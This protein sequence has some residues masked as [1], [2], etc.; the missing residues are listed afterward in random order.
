MV[1]FHPIGIIITLLF[2]G[3]WGFIIYAVFALL[4][5]AKAT[6][7]ALNRIEI[8]LDRLREEMSGRDSGHS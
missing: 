4:G 8:K 7:Q 2:L 3:F 6:R 5:H 1:F